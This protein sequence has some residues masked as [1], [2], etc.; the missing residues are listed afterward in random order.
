MPPFFALKRL[1]AGTFPACSPGKCT[2]SRKVSPCSARKALLY[3]PTKISVQGEVKSLTGGDVPRCTKQQGEVR[4]PGRLQIGG[5]MAAA[6]Q[7]VRL[8][9]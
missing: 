3:S 8:T 2:K 9:W 1:F 5:P 4:D 7:P 6:P